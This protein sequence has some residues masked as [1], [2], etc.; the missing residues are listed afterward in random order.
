VSNVDWSQFKSDWVSF[1][2]PGTV[3]EGTVLSVRIGSYQGKS[4][5]ELELRTVAGDV[6]VSAG[7]ANLQRQL[8]DDPPAVGDGIRIEYL[9]ESDHAQPG[10]N[11]AKLFKVVV[12]HQPGP[13]APVPQPTPNTVGSMAVGPTPSASDLV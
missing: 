1:K 8:A 5:P 12:T 4:Y 10:M 11:P 3:V 13:A 2:V 7:P 9:G 6:K